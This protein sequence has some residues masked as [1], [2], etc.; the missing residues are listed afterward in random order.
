MPE[1]EMPIDTDPEKI[2]TLGEAKGIIR[3]FLNLCEKLS[4][5][6]TQLVTENQ[7]LKQEI[8]KLKKQ[9]NPPQFP[10]QK[11]HASVTAEIAKQT[12]E[13][14]KFWQKR[15]KK[16]RI[17]IDREAQLPEVA[18]CACG[19]R[20]F[21]ILR[22]WQKIVQGIKILRDNVCYK[23]RD[24]QC[25][26]CGKVYISEIPEAIKGKSF[27][28]ETATIVSLLHYYCRMSEGL[29]QSFFNGF[30]LL[31]SKGEI[32]HMVLTNS[33]HLLPAYLHLR[34][35]GIKLSKYLHTD[36]TGK[37]R[38]SVQKGKKN[39]MVR[40]H[41]QIVC[42]TLLSI[43]TITRKY[44]SDSVNTVITKRGSKA[45]VISD[46]ASCNGK[47]LMAVW[48]QLCWIH[49]IRH[50]VKLLPRFHMH[51]QALARVLTSWWELYWLAKAYGKEPT[52]RARKEIEER[53][54]IMTQQT[55]G[56]AVLDTCL[57]RTTKKRK[58]LLTFLDHPGIPIENNQAERDV[59][60]AVI[61]DKI[62]GATKSAAGD[63]SLERHLSI[64][65]TAQKQGL[66]IF[67]TLHGLLT[68]QLDPF[69]LTAKQLA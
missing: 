11:K 22:T 40:Q 4:E 63:R 24:K 39:T 68:G 1:I 69:V 61:I 53:F 8:A 48:K 23:G 2:Q 47:R 5:Q 12:N 33:K 59:R 60:A 65:Q 30:G 7:N 35:W 62:S 26:N 42:H 37:K 55:T 64:M 16:D 66:N 52:E 17:V 34:V 49:E 43:F 51:K 25:K 6:I 41:I 28:E 36:A 15:S 45:V 67:D 58:R 46:D 21:I 14:K 9:A 29:I 44:N 19:S 31:I 18:S 54:D 10:T 38:Y 50:Y 57:Q 56:Y 13:G 27:S 32:T 20:E 3:K